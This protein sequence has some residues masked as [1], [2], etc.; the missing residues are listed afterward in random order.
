ME[1][2]PQGK[3]GTAFCRTFRPLKGQQDWFSVAEHAFSPFF[4]CAS[5]A[6]KLF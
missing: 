1:A 4:W 6:G 5:V 2:A 3:P